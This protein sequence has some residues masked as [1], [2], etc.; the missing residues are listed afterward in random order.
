MCCFRIFLGGGMF[1]FF[2]FFFF[3]FL[4]RVA[5]SFRLLSTIAFIFVL[6]Y[7]LLLFFLFFDLRSLASP[8]SCCLQSM[9]AAS[10]L[11]VHGGSRTN[12]IVK[13]RALLARR[14]CDGEPIVRR[15]KRLAAEHQLRQ[16]V[17]SL[18]RLDLAVSRHRQPLEHLPLLDEDRH[19]VPLALRHAQPAVLAVN[20]VPRLHRRQQTL[21]DEHVQQTLVRR[22]HHLPVRAVLSQQPVDARRLP[23][24]HA[25]LRQRCVD[26][27]LAPR[28]TAVDGDGGVG[29]GA[30]GSGRGAGTFA[31][32]LLQRNLLR[33]LARQ[34]RGLQARVGERQLVLLLC[35]H[36]LGLV[37]AHVVRPRVH[38]ALLL[39]EDAPQNVDEDDRRVAVERRRDRVHLLR[40]VLCVPAAQV[41]AQQPA[42]RHLHRELL[43]HAEG[44]PPVRED[45]ALRARHAL[46]HHVR[47][48]RVFPEQG[49]LHLRG[50]GHR[51]LQRVDQRDLR[52][53]GEGQLFERVV[54]VLHLVRVAQL[55]PPRRAALAAALV[56]GAREAVCAAVEAAD[57][58][59]VAR[60]LQALV[61]PAAEGAEDAAHARHPELVAPVRLVQRRRNVQEAA[62]VL[63]HH[64]R[65]VRLR[66]PVDRAGERRT[67]VEELAAVRLAHGAPHVHKRRPHPPVGHLKLR[68]E[69]GTADGHRP[70]DAEA[71]RHLARAEGD[72]VRDVGGQKLE[73][74]VGEAD[75]RETL[76][77]VA[78]QL[79]A[80]LDVGAHVERVHAQ[81]VD[82]LVVDLLAREGDVLWASLD[83]AGGEEGVVLRVVRRDDGEDADGPPQVVHAAR[84]AERAACADAARAQH[85]GVHRDAGDG[86]ALE[87][88]VLLLVEGLGLEAVVRHVEHAELP[89]RH[90]LLRVEVGEEGRRL[91]VERRRRRHVGRRGRKRRREPRAV[92]REGGV[93]QRRERATA[94]VKR[95]GRGGERGLRARR[96]GV[97]VQLR[98]VR[99]VR[100]DVAVVVEGHRRRRAVAGGG[101]LLLGDHGHDGGQVAQR[102]GGVHGPVRVDGQLDDGALPVE[103]DLA[104]V[105]VEVRRLH[106]QVRVRCDE[107]V[108]N[109]EGVARAG[110]RARGP[111]HLGED[112]VR[113]LRA[114]GHLHHASQH[115]TLALQGRVALHA[116]ALVLAEPH[117]VRLHDDEVAGQ[118]AVAGGEVLLL[119]AQLADHQ[120]AALPV[121]RLH[122]AVGGVE[123]VD[124]ACGVRP[125]RGEAEHALQQ[126][127]GGDAGLSL[128]RRDVVVE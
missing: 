97:V 128:R 59:D 102:E 106:E 22:Q 126:L 101:H 87:A 34:L 72:F 21:H 71:G 53:G 66:Q 115:H 62:Q 43:E 90:H 3:L 42:R 81:A 1:F 113:R 6:G 38:V 58:R 110:L 27:H 52:L 8:L 49:A 94:V 95:G 31:L 108:C 30:V 83:L 11:H 68:E 48:R 46:R 18:G 77:E 92:V 116:L 120:R 117:E 15:H 7:F 9:L 5:S 79:A 105:Q 127:A 107:G 123:D 121:R 78:L 50:V 57:G 104:Q 112:A 100:Q 70:H 13:P 99:V 28:P 4:L 76:P 23:P 73:R 80:L 55:A 63:L 84:H 47:Q 25:A 29:R 118:R 124:V 51:A 54:R 19:V 60:V 125:R 67:P 45:T 17:L 109:R 24:A 26:E 44:R 122:E 16:L 82:A 35:R 20:A 64:H 10:L 111:A 39:R 40:L 14:H 91:V 61:E 103:A 2:F 74:G 93:A 69:L 32:L 96:V 75:G 88:A 85:G 65:V 114:G 33:D 119:A 37:V 86:G 36:L 12:L 56:G 41:V 89:E 98:R